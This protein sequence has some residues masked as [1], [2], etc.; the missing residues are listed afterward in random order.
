MTVKLMTYCLQNDGVL[1]N[2][3]FKSE[4]ISNEV[5]IFGTIGGAPSIQLSG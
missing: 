2:L 5:A 4:T 3:L 1:F